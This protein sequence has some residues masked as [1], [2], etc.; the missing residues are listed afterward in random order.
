MV[1]SVENKSVGVGL[2]ASKSFPPGKNVLAEK[3]VCTFRLGETLS[4]HNTSARIASM[5]SRAIAQVKRLCTLQNQK[6]NCSRSGGGTMEFLSILDRYGVDFTLK[7]KCSGNNTTVRGF[8][9]VFSQ[10]EHSCQPNC[11]YHVNDH[12]VLFV[13]ATR[14]IRGGEPITVAKQNVARDFYS[15]RQAKHF[16]RFRTDCNCELC[17]SCLNDESVMALDTDIK[18]LTRTLVRK[19]WP[20]SRPDESD[21]EQTDLE[22]SEF[23]LSDLERSLLSIQN[24][25]SILE[26][27]YQNLKVCDF[28]LLRKCHVD[29]SATLLYL[30]SYNKQ[31]KDS[32]LGLP[33]PT[34]EYD[35][36]IEEQIK[37]AWG[38]SNLCF[39]TTCE[40][41]MQ[42]ESV[43]SIK[44]IEPTPYDKLPIYRSSSASETD[45][46]TNSR[47][48]PALGSCEGGE[49]YHNELVWLESCSQKR[50]IRKIDRTNGIHRQQ[51]LL[52]SNPLAMKDEIQSADC[53]VE[54]EDDY[55]KGFFSLPL[56]FSLARHPPMALGQNHYCSCETPFSPL[57][58][59]SESPRRA[60]RS[61]GKNPKMRRHQVQQKHSLGTL[62]GVEH[63]P[64][65]GLGLNGKNMLK[66]NDAF[67][68]LYDFGDDGNDGN[69]GSN[70]SSDSCYESSEQPFVSHLQSDSY[71]RRRHK[72]NKRTLKEESPLDVVSTVHIVPWLRETEHRDSENVKLP[73]ENRGKS[74]GRCSSRPSKF[75][76][77]R[78]PTCTK[79]PLSP[80]SQPSSMF[81]SRSPHSPTPLKALRE[82]SSPYEPQLSRAPITGEGA[83][84]TTG[85]VLF[86]SPNKKNSENT[87]AHI[88]VPDGYTRDCIPGR[89]NILPALALPEAAL[90]T[91][92]GERFRATVSGQALCQPP[93]PVD[94]QQERKIS[95]V[96]HVRSKM[97]S[98][99]L[100]YN[101]R[102]NHLCRTT[103][104]NAQAHAQVR[105]A[106]MLRRA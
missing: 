56:D 103:E 38:Y 54:E 6:L 58:K 95:F 15:E 32:S 90:S 68:E 29:A 24:L 97:Q 17:S 72:H 31:N 44:G 63:E 55:L 27:S 33:T 102:I 59:L 86:G 51:K 9:T 96:D 16:E 50:S 69:D 83:A 48:E 65:L 40:E 91:L 39:G 93:H 12:G 41:S 99:A 67:C 25:I 87:K 79:I 106:Y 74:D 73:S 23:V 43:L 10:I 82:G 34:S 1:F 49:I 14:H 98:Q 46:T 71:N 60:E 78:M 22:P 52:Q 4:P 92:A 18:T 70:S 28:R 3:N 80:S 45:K 35:D 47:S 13:F 105:T 94:S 61:R 66:R 77:I 21:T 75:E 81:V 57:S 20:S 53:A 36:A 37:L 64:M 89:K 19:L 85:A 88:I 11:E 104:T 5:P 30:K 26:I 100:R 7:E 76:I 84:E 101:E 2:F 62:G 8:F 42:F